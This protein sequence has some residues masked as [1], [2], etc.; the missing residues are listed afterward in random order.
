MTTGPGN[1]S[2]ADRIRLLLWCDRHCCLCK[3]RCELN[4]EL[5][6]IVSIKDGGSG[7]AANA[8]PLCFD[9][10]A[11]TGFYNVDHPRGTK[12]RVDE[13][14]AR[15]DQ[16]YEEFTR[17]LVPPIHYT[18][19]NDLGK[20]E[21]GKPRIRHLPDVGFILSHRG[22]SLPVHVLVTLDIRLDGRSLGH[23]GG[24]Y[25]GEKPWRLNPTVT[26]SG[27][28][29][30]PPAVVTSEGRLEI[31]AHV[32]IVDEFERRHELLPVGWVYVRRTKN[33][34]LPYWYFEP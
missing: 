23:P 1:F 3:R 24:H 10:H 32:A 17:H 11:K 30:V 13:L 29:D 4:I 9:C 7:D 15:R 8:I 14:K 6:H 22:A 12:Y 26:Y 16:V 31:E 20:D 5:A 34:E 27:H 19:T 21:T 2:E 25:G 28:F 33:G 18:V